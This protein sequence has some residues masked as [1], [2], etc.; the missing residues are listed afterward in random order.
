MNQ[1]AETIINHVADKLN[2]EPEAILTPSRSKVLAPIRCICIHEIKANTGLSHIKIA[3][4]F[5]CN[6]HCMITNRLQVYDS[7]LFTSSSFKKMV[8]ISKFN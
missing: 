8:R 2:V 1:L 4:I 3:K 6:S 5:G 7:L